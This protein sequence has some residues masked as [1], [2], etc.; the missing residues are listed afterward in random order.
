[1]TVRHRVDI[2]FPGAQCQW[3]QE[4]PYT[5]DKS[6]ISGRPFTGHKEHSFSA[7]EE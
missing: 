3:L 6:T 1:M 5:E 4:V 2:R 7:R